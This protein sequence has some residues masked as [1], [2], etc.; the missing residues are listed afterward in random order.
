MNPTEQR[1]KDIVL[2]LIESQGMKLLGKYL[3][4]SCGGFVS[5]LGVFAAERFWD[6]LARPLI[7][8]GI[9]K[10]LLEVDRRKGQILIK[11]IDEAKVNHDE[12]A[13]I[14]YISEL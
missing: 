14:K 9:R 8:L 6:Y 4:A 13:Y 10:S 12:D 1:L 11:Q 2:R 3:T 7:L 5:W